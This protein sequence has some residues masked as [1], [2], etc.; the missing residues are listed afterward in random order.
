MTSKVARVFEANTPQE[1]AERYDDLAESYDDE[2]ATDV[3]PQR[4]VEVLVRYVASEAR[5]LDAGCGTGKVGQI[6]HD[7]GYRNLEGSDISPGMLRE[8]R[9]KNC[10]VALHQQALGE[11][12]AFPTGAFDAVVSVGLFLR[13]HAPSR[14]FDELIRITRPGGHI[15]FTLRPEFYAASD[16]KDKMEALV[17]AGRWCWVETGEPFNAGFKEF[18]DINLQV[19]VYRVN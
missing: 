1:L 17:D 5:I 10:Y 15:I 14:S 8:A 12:L 11:T 3:S 19:W 13:G 6:L 16:F 9:K 4:A 7:R 18:P 2:L